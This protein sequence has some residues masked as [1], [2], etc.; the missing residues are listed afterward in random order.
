MIAAAQIKAA[1]GLLAIDRR[2]L[3]ELSGL[4]LPTT[5]HMESS[6]GAV[7]GNVD[8]PMKLVAAPQGE[9]LDLMGEGAASLAEGR[10]VRSV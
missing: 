3:A 6:G 5:Q 2:R 10:G 7:R 1:R 8:S 9:G 4:S